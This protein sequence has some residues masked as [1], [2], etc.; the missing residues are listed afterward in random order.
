MT[1][2]TTDLPE[3]QYEYGVDRC[4]V[5]DKEKLR[6]YRRQRTEWLHLLNGDPVHSIWRQ[7]STMLWNDA[8][9]RVVNE[10]RG[11]ASERGYRSA[12]RNGMLASLL[13]Q[14][15]VATQ[16]LAIRRLMEKTGSRLDRQV[17][18]LRRLLD[19]IKAHR[20][21][22][23]REVY[24]GYD[25][26]PYDPDPGRKG[27]H[28]Q[29]LQEM[30]RGHSMYTRLPTNGPEA[31]SS[32]ERAHQSF[33]EIS[34]VAPL[35]RARDD[36]IRIAIFEHLE[37]ELENSGGRSFVQLSNKFIA[38]A[39]DLFSRVSSDATAD[40]TLHKI[41]RCHRAIYQVANYI[42]STLLW[43]STN[44]GFPTTQFNQF[45]QLDAPWVMTEDI[46][47]LSRFWDRHVTAIDAWTSCNV[48]DTNGG[49]EPETN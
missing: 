33:D 41:T 47:Q 22:V 11:L 17:V 46:E 10:S 5:Q 1:K 9:F 23:T 13:D 8:V 15:Y 49:S 32:A 27:F 25:G 40:L 16:A 30:E 21:L 39:A 12:A 37:S 43:H 38:H 28:E 36:V 31:W 42:D 35:D 6:Q 2:D 48:K 4:D 7:I 18:S 3:G 45:D 24:V 19:D 14:G 34:G 20:D 29:M 44:A 26:R